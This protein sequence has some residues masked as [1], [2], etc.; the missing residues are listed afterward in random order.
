MQ[1][2]MMQTPL[3][4]SSLL[5][6]ADR[7]HGGTEIVSR[8]VEGGLHR[9]TYRELHRRT[10]QLANALAALGIAE[11]DRVATLAW[12]GYRHME[13]YFAA[14]GAGSVLHT[15]NPRLH[16]EQIAWIVNHAEDRVLFFDLTFLP[17]VE[18][19]AP[20]CK[21]VRQWI[22]MTD[23]AHMPSS[24]A[25]NLM[26]YE[27]LLGAQPDRYT[28]PQFDENTASSLCYTSGTTGNP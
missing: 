22:A 9:T 27:D 10:R 23:R 19:I 24:E 18:A 11:S 14:S 25:L 6:H 13:I 15:I 28:W 5:E 3:L 26:C 16:A 17:L 1:G 20:H 8:T 7:H 2:L 12:N 21:G 4:I